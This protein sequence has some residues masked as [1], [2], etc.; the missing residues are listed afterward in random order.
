MEK[1]LATS[2]YQGDTRRSYS[3]MHR[4]GNSAASLVC[5]SLWVI[6]QHQHSEMERG[7]RGSQPFSFPGL[8]ADEEPSCILHYRIT[9]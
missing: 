7:A 3:N 2:K 8:A 4:Q 9:K 5:S 1:V 6:L